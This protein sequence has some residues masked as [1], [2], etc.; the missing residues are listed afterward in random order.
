[1]NRK[2]GRVSL[3][4]FLICV[5]FATFYGPQ[6][7]EADVP[8]T[9]SDSPFKLHIEFVDAQENEIPITMGLEATYVQAEGG[10]ISGYDPT[11]L[12][13]AAPLPITKTVGKNHFTLNM[14]GINK[15][16][17][18]LNVPYHEFIS[19][20]KINTPMP[21]VKS[22]QFKPANP[23][24]PQKSTYMR[25][26]L[27][28]INPSAKYT[29]DHILGVVQQPNKTFT[30]E[31]INGYQHYPKIGSYSG[32]II[33]WNFAYVGTYPIIADYSVRDGSE[34]DTLR[35]YV[36]Y[37]Q[38]QEIFEDETGALIP[39]P[40]GYTNQHYT[41]ITTQP[42]GYQM[43]N[44]S[45]L[46]ETYIDSNFIYTYKGW[47]KGNGNKANINK[48]FP[49]SIKFNAQIVD[50]LQ[51]EVHIVYDK[52]VL[53]TLDEEYINTNSG[54]IESS[55]NNIGQSKSD[56]DTFTKTPDPIK[57]DSSG[58][59]WEYQGW[60]L[61]TEPMSA[62]RPSSTPVSVLIDSNKSV[63][64]IYKKAEHTI[65]EKWV[66]QA[67]GTTLVPMVSNPK[68]SSVDDNEPFNGLATATIT[69]TGG[70]IWDYIGWEN[71]TDAAGTIN[72][73]ATYTINNIKGGKEIRYH[74]RS[75]N[76]TATLDLKPTPQVA[77]SGGAVSWSSRLTNTGT[78]T[79][80]NLK[81]KATGNWASGLS[82]PTQVTVTPA[83][84]AAQNFTVS[85][86]DWTSG[87]N[88][89]GISIPSAGPNNYADI[90]FTDTATGAVNQVLPAEIEIDGNMASSLT[91]ENFVR[92]DD[93][94]EPNLEPLGTAGLINIPDFRLEMWK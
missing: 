68:T 12:V 75:R 19:G 69:D 84:G 38:I 50:D 40:S 72:P 58:A 88:L 1:M 34:G 18:T 81:L 79:L 23:L 30:F 67:D 21:Y 2:I 66:D 87:F 36:Y 80:N 85:L 7:S 44:D 61:G 6:I 52:K 45:S 26:D 37:Y 17:T 62:M 70:G 16:I 59:D 42:F 82:H 83:S 71:V 39:A 22:I 28:S 86:G 90:T 65:T 48:T 14:P 51:N 20:L 8:F 41:N 32:L 63:Q 89:T 5:G 47:Y 92:I 10:S 53:R 31:M 93:P 11:T 74:Y 77:A 25:R 3:L 64:Y 46:P 29:I 15:T 78:S 43:T 35:L 4:L 27:N 73:A 13:N 94:D 56:G 33:G 54:T 91:A 24:L 57:T 9:Y 76:T 49:P 55:W 60:K